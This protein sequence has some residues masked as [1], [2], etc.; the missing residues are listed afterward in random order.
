MKSPSIDDIINE[1]KTLQIREQQLTDHLQELLRERERQPKTS[2]TN[3]R[4]PPPVPSAVS[5]GNPP[6]NTR[7]I[8]RWD[9]ID[10][11]SVRDRVRITNPVE[12]PHGKKHTKDDQ[13]GTIVRI[14]AKRL[15]IRTD[16]G[17]VIERAPTNVRK[18]AP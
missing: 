7:T 2:T 4:A 17:R 5:S 11:Y 6:T 18:Q 13:V 3:R 1:I 15:H 9:D 8:L 16:S 12:P 14:T 10:R